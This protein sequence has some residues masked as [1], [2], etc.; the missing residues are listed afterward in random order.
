LA[1]R[2]SEDGTIFLSKSMIETYYWCPYKFQMEMIHGG[3]DLDDNFAVA[4]GSR[5]HGF[6]EWFFDYCA[7]LPPERWEEF[8]PNSFNRDEQEMVLWWV[9]EERKRYY[10]NPEI[11]MPIQRELKIEY[12][13]KCLHGIVDRIDWIDKSKNEIAVVEYKTSKSFY[14]PSINRQLA[15]YKYIW[16]NSIRMGNIKYIRYIN[17]R[18][19]IY[20]LIPLPQGAMTR[21]TNKIEEIRQA[22]KSQDFPRKCTDV[23]FIHC[24]ICHPDEVGE[25]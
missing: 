8:V 22:I 5:F 13:E 17:P 11:F 2:Y 19:K 1:K 6:A 14:Q 18:L 3:E 24:G 7:A 4:I 15:F 16:D 9:K 23:K 21:M 10:E 25:I 20:E 12:T